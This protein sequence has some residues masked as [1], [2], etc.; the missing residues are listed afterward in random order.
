[1]VKKPTVWIAVS[2]LCLQFSA[3]VG[4][5]QK[6]NRTEKVLIS[7][8][9]PYDRVIAGIK[10]LGGKVTQQYTYVDGI[11]AEI[12]LE[13]M[14]AVRSL[15]GPNSITKDKD[16]P[17][18]IAANMTLGRKVQGQQVGPVQRAKTKSLKPI[19]ADTMP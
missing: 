7:T 1:M 5:A 6:S 12:P 18:P 13:S 14:A 4:L 17:H 15:V 10:S 9:Q 11:A 16:V 3:S 19:P 2:I 8:P